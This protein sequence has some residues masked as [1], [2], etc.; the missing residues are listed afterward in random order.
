[1]IS[2]C[3]SHRHSTDELFAEI[4]MPG[5][6]RDRGTCRGK[7][8]LEQF[9]EILIL[10]LEYIQRIVSSLRFRASSFPPAVVRGNLADVH[11]VK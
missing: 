4:S 9:Y 6:C 1:M 11:V 7:E 2:G 5:P 3:F 8:L 10:T